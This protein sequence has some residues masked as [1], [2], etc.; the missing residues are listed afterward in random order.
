VV[1]VLRADPGNMKITTRRDLHVAELMLRE[2][3]A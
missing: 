2:R 3:L 1:R